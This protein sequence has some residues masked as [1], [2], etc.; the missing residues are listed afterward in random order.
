MRI[1]V[2]YTA[3]LKFYAKAVLLTL[4]LTA[5]PSRFPSGIKR[6]VPV[7]AA[8]AVADLHC[9]PFSIQ[10]YHHILLYEIM[11]SVYTAVQGLSICV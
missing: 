3:D 2:L 6:A 9:V 10:T 1:Q 11:D 7:T 5:F 4:F 8:G